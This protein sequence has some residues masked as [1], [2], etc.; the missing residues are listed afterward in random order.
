[1]SVIVTNALPIFAVIAVGFFIGR[2]VYL[3]QS[4]TNGL[5]RFAF[6]L[7]M[8]TALFALTAQTRLV[9]QENFIFGACY[10]FAALS[11]MAAAYFIARGPLKL[12]R[13]D[14]GG[15]ALASV[16]GNAVFLGL[17]IALT[18]PGWAEK[19][20]VIFI[21]EWTMV[22]TIGAYLMSSSAGENHSPFNGVK[23]LTRNPLIIAIFA[24]IIYSAL[25]TMITGQSVLPAPIAKFCDFVGRAAGPAALFSLG[26][27]LATMKAPP[28]KSFAREMIVITVMKQIAVP[29]LFALALFTV[30]MSDR[31]WLGPAVLFTAMPTAVGAYVLASEFNSYVM[32]TAAAILVTT[33]VSIA[34][35]SVVLTLFA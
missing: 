26:L 11:V 22:I 24:G 6:A 31:E 19:F 3:S 29:S 20:A 16:L 23:K 8:P 17:S 18:L 33:T 27:F 4:D 12:S 10:A 7:A 28:I 14:A 5:N 15:F 1:M 25:A 13:Q 9:T 21:F 2:R 30:G 34:T 32:Q 35:I